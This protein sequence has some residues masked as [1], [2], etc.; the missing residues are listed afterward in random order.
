MTT[1]IIDKLKKFRTDLFALFKYRSDSTMD[2][3]DAFAGQPSKESIVKISLS[4]L[5]RRTY[6]SITDVVDNLFRQEANVNLKPDEMEEAHFKITELLIE[7]CPQP[8]K[9]PFELMAVD[10]SSNDRI[11]SKKLE[12]RGFVHSPTK[13]P[14][15][16]PITVG[17][18][19][20]TVVF[21]PEKIDLS[22]P[23]WVVPLSTERVKTKESGTVVGMQQIINIATSDHFKN[24]L[25]VAVSDSA[26]S[27]GR[28]LK[29]AN[30]ENNLINISRLRNNRHFHLPISIV[31]T[32]KPKKVGR[33][34]VYGECWTL[35][36]PG[37]PNEKIIEKRFTASGRVINIVIE[38]WNDRVEKGSDE[39]AP[40]CLMQSGLQF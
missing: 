21:L 40:F 34:K 1:A 22:E 23:H 32:G 24:K 39:S 14:G 7:Q 37:E 6:S 10:C 16:L 12:D 35:K 38:R 25:C 33:P 9:R 15:Q 29:N 4:N 8:I 30:N 5:F 26:Y 27:N 13:V 11:Y 28:R 2:L 18:Q 19:Y 3:I 36:N 20:S 31:E 17:H